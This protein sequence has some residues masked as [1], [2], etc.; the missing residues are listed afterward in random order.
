MWID[1]SGG[2]MPVPRGTLVDIRCR[3]G[4][5]FHSQ[6]AGQDAGPYRS[7]ASHWAH[8]GSFSDIVAYR[9]VE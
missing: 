7:H 6:P 8:T 5:V 9:V 1:W 3:D 4:E 2:D